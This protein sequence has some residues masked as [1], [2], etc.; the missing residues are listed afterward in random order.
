MIHDDGIEVYLKPGG[1]DEQHLRR[2]ELEEEP[3]ED[4]KYR[5]CHVLVG[6]ED[7]KVVIRFGETFR[8]FTADCIHVVIALG[9]GLYLTKP[10]YGNYHHKDVVQGHQLVWMKLDDE[11]LIETPLIGE[12]IIYEVR[13][14][15][16]TP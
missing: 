10:S 1:D 16:R 12:H 4:G 6:N 2:C 5:Q 13:M 9:D 11:R 14:V 15:D 8:L 7:L 3:S